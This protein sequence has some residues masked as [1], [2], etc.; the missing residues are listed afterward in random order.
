MATKDI[1]TLQVCL[2]VAEMHRQRIRCGM[3]FEYAVTLLEQSTGQPTKVCKNAIYREVD[4]KMVEWGIYRS[5]GWLSHQG[6][7]YLQQSI[8]ASDAISSQE[9]KQ[10]LV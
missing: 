5:I 3:R 9:D 7:A 6:I 10:P 8:E 2:A 4:R 1:S